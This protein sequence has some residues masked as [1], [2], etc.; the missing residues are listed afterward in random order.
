M[1]Y[2]HAFFLK[3]GTPKYY[4]NCVYPIDIHSPAEAIVF[5]SGE[6]NRFEALTERVLF[7]MLQNMLSPKGFFYFRKEKWF[8]NKIPYIRW[9]QAW[10]FHALT[11]YLLHYKKKF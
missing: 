9:S 1:V 6:G 2:A 4:H 11:E 5:F 10:V 7:W 8:V 3:D